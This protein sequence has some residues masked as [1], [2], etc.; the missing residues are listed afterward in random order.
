VVKWQQRG[1]FIRSEQVGE[2]AD[3]GQR[4]GLRSYLTLTAADYVRAARQRIEVS[5]AILEMFDRF[6]ALVTPTVIGEATTLDT[7]LSSSFGRRGSSVLSAL[8]GV[9]GLSVP[10]GFGPNG[11]P[12]G[13]SITGD[14]FAENTI[15]QIG[16]LYQQE[17]D[18]HRRRPSVSP[19]PALRDARL[20]SR[21]VMSMADWR[22][23][24]D[25]HEK[26]GPVEVRGD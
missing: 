16:M 22:A 14:R 19:G 4:D 23:R 17:T 20:V 13:L 12:L 24:H 18:W 7:N 6:D 26:R 3:P 5:R 10:M 11:L 25:R 8:A 2:L 15:L 1:E 21:R 9:P